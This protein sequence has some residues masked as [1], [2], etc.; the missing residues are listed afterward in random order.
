M[1]FVYYICACTCSGWN[2]FEIKIMEYEVV[3]HLRTSLL[4]L[5][6]EKCSWP[7]NFSTFISSCSM[8]IVI[9]RLTANKSQ[10]YCYV[11]CSSEMADSLCSR[12]VCHCVLNWRTFSNSALW[13]V[14][15]QNIGLRLMLAVG[16]Y[17]HVIR[18]Q[19]LVYTC[20]VF[21]SRLSNKGC[22]VTIN[23]V[24]VCVWE[25]ERERERENRNAV[26]FLLVRITLLIKSVICL[27][28]IYCSFL[29]S[30]FWSYPCCLIR[31]LSIR[32]SLMYN[33]KQG[34]SSGNHE[35]Y[36]HLHRFLGLRVCHFLPKTYYLIK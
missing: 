33:S 18:S 2:R 1:L 24:C 16:G 30:N 17:P 13:W 25:R 21:L 20:L 28:R 34:F 29:N 7:A 10:Y 27:F 5:V 8:Q 31:D 23:C 12:F 36:L 3:F 11:I 9:N 4:L 19:V 26:S 22:K 6:I 35:A 14:C 32:K 15:T